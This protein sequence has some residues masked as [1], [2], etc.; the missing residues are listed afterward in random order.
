[1]T[2]SEGINPDMTFTV[3]AD[4][5]GTNP[6]KGGGDG[7][8]FTVGAGADLSLPLIA[9]LLLTTLAFLRRYPVTDRTD[10]AATTV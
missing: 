1:M 9:L 2:V 6:I 5:T 4:I 10:R 7:C 8:Q 3:T